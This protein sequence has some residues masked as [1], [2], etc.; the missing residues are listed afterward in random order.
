MTKT[1]VKTDQTQRSVGQPCQRCNLVYK[2]LCH[3][4]S[5]GTL[6]E[7]GPL[8]VRPFGPDETVVGEGVAPEFVGILRQGILR[9]VRVNSDG[10]RNLLEVMRP[11]D[12]LGLLETGP[13]DF[14]VETVTDVEICMFDAGKIRRRIGADPDFRQEI[15]QHISRQYER[16]LEA[17]WLRGALTSRERILAF[18][19]F[20]TEF[21]PVEPQPDGSLMITMVLTRRD[22]ADLTGTTLETICRLLGELSQ[23]G[24]VT[25]DGPQRYRI[26]DIVALARLAGLEGEPQGLRMLDA[27]RALQGSG[28]FAA[29]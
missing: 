29:E 9:R 1:A 16:Q 18:L 2:D 6:H 24:L 26:V 8:R 7:D 10:R 4:T 17:I 25:P 28:R 20:A 13:P 12:L 14:A 21:M 11:G 27:A 5:D 23:K 22:W 15:L 19:L 3:A